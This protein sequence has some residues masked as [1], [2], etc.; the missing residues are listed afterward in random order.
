MSTIATS[1]VTRHRFGVILSV[2]PRV[3]GGL[4]GGAV[5]TH[6]TIL[7][8]CEIPCNPNPAPPGRAPALIAERYD[9]PSS[10]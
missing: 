8:P 6:P 2:V 5:M 4:T 1:A 10:T 9:R 3:A 7:M